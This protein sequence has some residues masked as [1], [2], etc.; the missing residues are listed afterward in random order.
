MVSEGN[1]P[2]EILNIQ[3]SQVPNRVNRDGNFV[4]IKYHFIAD[5]GQKQFTADEVVHMSGEDPDYGKR[6][7]WQAIE[8][9]EK[10]SWTAHVQIM[11]PEEADAE[12]LGFDPFDVTKVWPKDKFPVCYCLSCVLLVPVRKEN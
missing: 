2:E 5:H 3:C 12:K 7:L 4:Y 11:K 9:G 10:V 8:K 6:D 1:L